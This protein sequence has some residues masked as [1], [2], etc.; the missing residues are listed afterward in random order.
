MGQFISLIFVLL[1]F[2]WVSMLESI[3]SKKLRNNTEEA[4]FVIPGAS[5]EPENGLRVKPINDR[6]FFLLEIDWY[7]CD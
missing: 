2:H 6:D 5:T 4:P 1:T 7:S 3:S